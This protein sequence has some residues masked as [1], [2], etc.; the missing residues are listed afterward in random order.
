MK[1][2]DD[3]NSAEIIF[4]RLDEKQKLNMCKITNN[5]LIHEKNVI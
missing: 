3:K 4:R 1:G 2:H 5:W